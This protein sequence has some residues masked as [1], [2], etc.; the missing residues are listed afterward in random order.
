[1]QINDFTIR[2]YGFQELA[3]LYFP[4][5]APKSAS[6][7]LKK[8]ISH[9]FLMEKLALAGYRSGQKI[10]TPRQVALIVGHL[11]EP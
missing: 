10:L 6:A 3:L 8:W 5:S 2:A 1:M 7:Q 11:G 4:N 9:P